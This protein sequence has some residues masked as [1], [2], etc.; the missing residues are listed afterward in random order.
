MGTTGYLSIND[1]KEK[2]SRKYLIFLGKWLKG[3][4]FFP[5]TL[6]GCSIGPD[7]PYGQR[8][9]NFRELSQKEKKCSTLGYELV[10]TQRNTRNEGTQ[11]FLK[12]IKFTSEENFLVF[13]GKNEEF[14]LFKETIRLIRNETPELDLWTMVNPGKILKYFGKWP[15]ITTVIRYFCDSEEILHTMR[16]IPLPIPT[17]FIEQNQ[18]LLKELLDAVLPE[19]RINREED[20]LTRRYGLKKE[21]DF[22]FRIILP[23]E[24]DDFKPF[25]DLL[26]F[27]SELALWNPQIK[28]VIVIENKYSFLRFPILN[29]W[30]K[31]W[32]SGNSVALIEPCK[33]LNEKNLFYWGDLDPQG[34]GIL[35]LFRTLFPDAESLFM[36]L[37]SY[38]QF[39]EF[40]FPADL[41]YAREDLLLTD[42]ESEC[43]R[44]LV[45]NKP[46]SR[47][48]QERISLDW[49]ERHIK[50]L[51]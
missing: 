16:E 24:M 51:L 49:I 3:E 47:I 19:D 45:E 37:D 43:Y 12:T 1:V 31:I 27:P 14:F 26:V 15:L 21:E 20:E 9:E 7:V 25:R 23:E 33:W 5:L 50:P 34:F 28:N 30:L 11:T 35:H 4:D 22:R 29:G 13:I 2:A 17:K 39:K 38:N 8:L 18:A 44:Y 40:A 48:E 41:F 36:N 32:G 46:V 10:W 6:T 42:E